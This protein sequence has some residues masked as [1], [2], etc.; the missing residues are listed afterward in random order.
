MATIH[1]K[2]KFTFTKPD[3]TGVP[4]AVGTHTDVPVEIAKHPFV[5]AHCADMPVE[6]DSKNNGA[7][8][9]LLTERDAQIIALTAERDD[10]RTLLETQ[11]GQ[12]T[13][14]TAE[15]DSLA[16]QGAELQAS[17]TPAAGKKKG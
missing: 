11:T 6:E 8:L 1:V 4:F 5:K 15:R 7:V 2:E 16:D 17:G 12:I 14:L 3:G 13:A 10:V 9:A